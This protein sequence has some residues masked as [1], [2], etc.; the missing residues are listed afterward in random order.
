[1]DFNSETNYD[2]SN[3]IEMLSDP[4]MIGFIRATQPEKPMLFPSIFP[5]GG[6]QDLSV[7]YYLDEMGDVVPQAHYMSFDSET[8][9]SRL[10]DA[11]EV[12]SNLV[13]MGLRNEFNETEIRKIL[14]IPQDIRIARKWDFA[15][16]P[17]Q[18]ILSG[19]ERQETTAIEALTD[20]RVAFNEGKLKG[21]SIEFDLPASQ[22][23]APLTGSDVWTDPTSDPWG[24]IDSWCEIMDGNKREDIG[25]WYMDRNTWR[26]LVNHPETSRRIFPLANGNAVPN[27][28][29]VREYVGSQYRGV[30]V[31]IYT[32]RTTNL[33]PDGTFARYNPWPRGRFVMAPAGILGQTKESVTTE[34]LSANFP[35]I[36]MEARTGPWISYDKH[37]DPVRISIIMNNISFITF[38]KAHQVLIAQVL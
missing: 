24:D 35:T 3:I 13:K 16:R 17:A 34:A 4:E 11:E 36:P 12:F 20:S 38:P 8:P 22:R 7:G 19:R 6:T 28:T 9:L 10:P 5:I 31:T 15:Q 25:A 18:L 1:M 23:P 32:R 33:M 26:A 37:I 14:M 27:E 2:L 21:L 30:T 29:Q